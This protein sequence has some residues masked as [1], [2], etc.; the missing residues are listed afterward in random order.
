MKK[1]LF[2]VLF[3]FAMAACTTPI[4]QRPQPHFAYKAYPPVL[5]NVANIRVEEAYVSPG[6]PPHAEQLMPLPLPQAVADWAHHRFQATG[7]AGTAVITIKDASVVTQ[8]LPRTKGVKGWITVDQA[9]RFDAKIAIDMHVENMTS[10]ENGS[11]T[12][13]LTRGQSI[14]EDASIEDRDHIWTTM[15]ES[16]LTDLD[17]GTQKMLRNR[18]PFLIKQ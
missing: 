15:E 17:A 10:G 13:N 8:D 2:P 11:G 5:L 1:I 6:Q 12:V 16:M 14:G 7:S 3:A 18:L 9:E 4:E